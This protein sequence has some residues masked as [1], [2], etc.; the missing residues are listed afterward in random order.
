MAS[1]TADVAGAIY[2]ATWAL[3]RQI[4]PQE[5]AR[6]ALSIEPTDGS[7]FPHIVLFDHRGGRLWEGL[8]PCPPLEVVILD[9][10]GEV[11]TV[12]FNQVD[13]SALLRET[14]PQVAEALAWV[15][16]GL[17]RGEPA[18]VGK[19]A[20]LSALAN[21]RVLYKPQLEAV[22]EAAEELGALGVNVAHSGT[23]LGVL[24]DPRHHDSQAA[25]RYLRTR[26]PDL[27][28]CLPRRLV[29][30]GQVRVE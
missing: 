17:A 18:L 21:Q 22:L 16:E 14:E 23:V 3:G 29:G 5:A 19:G 15:R 20:T 10:G 27:Q 1:S 2:A 25:C 4:T 26:F 30:G 8:G 6:L 11:D 12:T 24:L 28:L 13:R 7:L 9:F